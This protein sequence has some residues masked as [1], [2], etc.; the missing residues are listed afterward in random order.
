MLLDSDND[1]IEK[2]IN[3]P[4]LKQLNEL[5]AKYNLSCSSGVL[6]LYIRIKRVGIEK[7]FFVSLNS[8]EHFLC[9][10]YKLISKRV[11][12]SEIPWS[13]DKFTISD[14]VSVNLANINSSYVIG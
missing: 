10:A 6:T 11:S 13:S 7:G 1:I 8:G 4:L 14:I 12:E 5:D 9:N 3:D 2:G